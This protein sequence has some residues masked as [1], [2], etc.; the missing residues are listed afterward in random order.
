MDTALVVGGTRFISRHTVEELLNH[1][2]EVTFF[3]R[4]NHANPFSDAEDVDHVEGDRDDRTA[5]EAAA[6]SVAPDVVIDC[7]A[8]FPE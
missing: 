3:N 8:Y 2:Y 1:D 6:L 7:V 4:G 5:L